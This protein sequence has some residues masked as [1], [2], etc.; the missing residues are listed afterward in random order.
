MVYNLIMNPTDPTQQTQPDPTQDPTQALAA[1]N[2]ALLTKQ[3][4]QQEQQQSSFAP[5]QIS[6][7][8]SQIAPK[9]TAGQVGKA[10]ATP[11]YAGFCQQFI[12]DTVGSKERYPT[13]FATWQAK[14][15]NGQAQPG[16]KG[17]KP[18]DIIEF[19][20]D[21]SNGGLGHAA[22][23]QKD[24]NLKM[25]TDSGIKTFS[26]EEWTRYTGQVPLGHYTPK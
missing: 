17:I 6:Q 18:G 23:V 7:A 22:I 13:A 14:V 19:Q 25:A 5:A 20:P 11:N 9:S 8:M 10:I 4:Q 26:L 21:D 16:T 15:Q 3:K 12:D 24:G 2:Q 1:N